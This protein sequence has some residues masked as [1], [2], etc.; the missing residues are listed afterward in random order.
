PA[1]TVGEHS[2]ELLNEFGFSSSDISA[3]FE[4]GTV[5]GT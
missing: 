1:P 2:T 3:L 4:A 5:G